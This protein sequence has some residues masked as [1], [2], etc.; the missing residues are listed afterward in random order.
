M[1]LAL[2]CLAFAFCLAAATAN[3]D[4]IVDDEQLTEFIPFDYAEES[5]DPDI[6]GVFGPLYFTI[7]ASL[8]TL[9]GV[10]CTIKRVMSIRSAG[11]DFL[12]AVEDCNTGA[13]MDFNALINQVQAVV[14][15]CNDIIN[16]NSNVCNNGALDDEV[17]ANKKTPARCASKLLGKMITLK[18]QISKTIKLSKKLPSTPGTYAGCATSAVS[19]MISVFTEFPTFVKNCSK[20]KN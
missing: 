18:K 2:L 12:E 11:V 15:T 10:N 14:N 17:G 19:D 1:K 13:L 4:Y 5:I 16:L 20:L 8:R 6:L 9:K 3:T 7:K